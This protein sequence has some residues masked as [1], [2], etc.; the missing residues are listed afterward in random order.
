MKQSCVG[1]T[2]CLF[3]ITTELLMLTIDAD[4]SISEWEKEDV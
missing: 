3:T 1:F 4:I 2:D